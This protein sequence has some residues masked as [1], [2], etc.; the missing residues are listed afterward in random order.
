MKLPTAAR[1]LLRV[2]GLLS[3]SLACTAMAHATAI[4]IVGAGGTAAGCGYPT[5]QAAVTAE[6]AYQAAHPGSNDFIYVT[7]TQQYTGQAITITNQN[8]H[9]IGGTDD[10]NH[11]TPSGTTTVSGAGGGSHSVISI[12]GNSNV[13]ISN[14]TV[15]GGHDGSNSGGGIDFQGAGSLYIS[16]STITNNTAGYGGGINF[17]GYNGSAILTLG[18]ETLVT[19]NTAIS[20]G[21]VRV[22]GDALLRALEPQ[23]WIAYNQATGSDSGGFGGGIEVIG[24]AEADLGSPGYEFIS[25]F[26][27][28]LTSNEA[29][30]G[31]GLSVNAGTD[32]GLT[33][34]VRLFSTNSQV[35]VRIYGNTASHVGG[36]VYLQPYVSTVFGDRAGAAICGSGY[37]IDQNIAQEGSALYLDASVSTTHDDLGSSA[38]LSQGAIDGNVC[39]G[40]SAAA[41]GAVRCTDETCNSIDGNATMNV[42]G[43]ATAGSAILVQTTSS[44]NANRVRLQGNNGAH[45]LRAIGDGGALEFTGAT[46]GN[47]LVTGNISR[48]DLILEES[49]SNFM[50]IENCTIANNQISQGVV[51]RAA[52]RLFMSDN[53][54]AQG[55]LTTLVFTGAPNWL[56]EL[57]DNLSMEVASMAAGTHIVQADP[58]FVDVANG[59]FHLRANSLAVDFAATA[60]TPG[61]VDLDGRPREIDLATVPNEFGPRDLGAY[62]RPVGSCASSDS[63][64]CDG[65]EPN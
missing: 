18:H 43:Q 34:A 21:G 56:V 33:A 1:N 32:S 29:L 26:L 19:N 25:G 54:I 30:Y 62:E 7:R 11:Y 9:I 37:R 23:I 50:S 39:G 44:F 57:H 4:F 20:G 41:L 65:F 46:L 5:I 28:L 40:D 52:G 47:A 15:S 42:S 58:A 16:D 53:I 55:S 45:V 36:G 22:E 63:I 38:D 64:F 48:G 8:L 27:P 51:V 35:P 24:P 59:D 17:N 49:G 2:V 6:I 61:E 3:T 12:R 10:C 13:T 14:L 31:G 60:T